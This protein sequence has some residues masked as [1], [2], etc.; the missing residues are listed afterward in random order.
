MSVNRR[1]GKQ[2]DKPTN[3]ILF[4]TQ[5]KKKKLLK[6]NYAKCNQQSHKILYYIITFIRI[7]EN[8][9]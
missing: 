2:P 5:K 9:S 4:N 6:N 1:L 8:L 3:R 7:L